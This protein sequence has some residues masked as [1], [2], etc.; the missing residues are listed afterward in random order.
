MVCGAADFE[1]ISREMIEKIAEVEGGLEEET[2]YDGRKL[3][4]TEES[5]RVSGP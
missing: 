1:V 2:T 4:W 3:R 5:G